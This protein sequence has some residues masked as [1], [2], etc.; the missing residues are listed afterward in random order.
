[1]KH[2]SKYILFT[3]IGLLVLYILAL[4]YVTLLPDFWAGGILEM[5][6]STPRPLV[7]LRLLDTFFD[8]LRLGA[9]TFL[10]QVGG[11]IL[12]LLPL[13]LVSGCLKKG[14]LWVALVSLLIE[15]SQLL[16]SL[17]LGFVYRTFDVD[18]L[19][20]NSLGGFLGY[21]VAR[22]VWY[23]GKNNKA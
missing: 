20:M 23:N 15:V 4:L 21:L 11:N 14:W 18:D 8:S 1:M 13:G 19:W 9:L 7:K 5:D 16:L 3:F 6:A 2:T 22:K 17:Q 10:I 12:L